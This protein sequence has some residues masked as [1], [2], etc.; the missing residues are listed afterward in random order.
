MKLKNRTYL[1]EGFFTY[2]ADILSLI[3]MSWQV[4]H[5]SVLMPEVLGT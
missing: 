3:S 5:Q 4:S 1:A 2:I